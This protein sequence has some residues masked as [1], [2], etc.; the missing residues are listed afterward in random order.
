MAGRFAVFATC[1]I[2][3]GTPFDDELDVARD[4]LDVVRVVALRLAGAR[5]FAGARPFDERVEPLLLRAA[6]ERLVERFVV[7]I[8]PTSLP[9]LPVFVLP[10]PRGTHADEKSPAPGRAR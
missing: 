4:E 2:V 10:T 3:D 6:V 5:F 9:K 1:L 7:A 8:S